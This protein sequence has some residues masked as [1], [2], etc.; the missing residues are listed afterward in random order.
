MRHVGSAV[1]GVTYPFRLTRYAITCITA[2]DRAN[3]DWRKPSSSSLYT[4]TRTKSIDMEPSCYAPKDTTLDDILLLALPEHH[5]GTP[6]DA[7]RTD[8]KLPWGLFPLLKFDIIRHNNV[9]KESL[10]LVDREEATRAD[11]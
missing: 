3:D 8:V 2:G 5:I 7:H 4:D 1:D 10:D 6:R 9:C 11:R